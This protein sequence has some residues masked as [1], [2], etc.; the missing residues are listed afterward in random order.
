[1]PIQVMRLHFL[2]FKAI[3]RLAFLM[4][5]ARFELE[6]VLVLGFGLGLDLELFPALVVGLGLERTREHLSYWAFIEIAGRTL[7]V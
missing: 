6:P 7:W 3:R 2:V 4:R 5:L 1:M